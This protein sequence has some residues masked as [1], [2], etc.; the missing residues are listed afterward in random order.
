MKGYI[1][2]IEGKPA[3]FDGFQICFATYYGTP[4]IIRETLA[5]IKRDRETTQ[6]NREREGFPVEMKKYGHF[7]FANAEVSRSLPEP[8]DGN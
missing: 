8:P 4:N 3:T 1:H 6:R 7:R 5:E 2:T